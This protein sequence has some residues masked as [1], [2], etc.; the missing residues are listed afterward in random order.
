MNKPNWPRVT[1]RLPPVN[2]RVGDIAAWRC[3]GVVQLGGDANAQVALI[4][5]TVL[6]AAGRLGV[7]RGRRAVRV[8]QTDGMRP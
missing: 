6:V 4:A 3:G 8:E 7:H 1:P 5:G 2:V